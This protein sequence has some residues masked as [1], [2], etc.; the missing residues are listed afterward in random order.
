MAYRTTVRLPA[1][2]AWFLRA[3]AA[4]C[5]LLCVALWWYAGDQPV[6]CAVVTVV[7]LGVAGALLGTRGRIEVDDRHLRLI[8]VPFFRKTLPR[9]E[10]TSVELSEVDPWR[11]FHGFGYRLK[12]GGLVGF[13]FRRGPAVRL[14]TRDGRTYLIGDP[15]AEDLLSALRG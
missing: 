3:V 11:E 12:G 4:G 2:V 9:Q 13:A 1:G 6:A 10:I 14:T 8:V 15:A 5:V 7:V